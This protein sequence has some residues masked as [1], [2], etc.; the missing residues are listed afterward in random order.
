[1]NA[2]LTFEDGTTGSSTF[3]LGL[4]EQG[5][6]RHLVLL[7][8]TTTGPAATLLSRG[9]LVSFSVSSIASSSVP[10]IGSSRLD[11]NVWVRR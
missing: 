4:F 9:P 7:P 1:V 11:V 6:T 2:T 8:P 5:T 3:L 10:S